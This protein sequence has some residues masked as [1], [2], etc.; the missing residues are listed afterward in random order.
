M[1]IKNITIKI[2]TPT[3]VL[4][5]SPIAVQPEKVISD[6]KSISEAMIVYFMIIVLKLF[7]RVLRFIKFFFQ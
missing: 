7:F 4:K 3:P 2:P 6:I 1:A 5:I